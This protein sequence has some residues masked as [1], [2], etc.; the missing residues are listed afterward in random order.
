MKDFKPMVEEEII[1]EC[2]R[3]AR[4]SN[5][6]LKARMDLR[7]HLSDSGKFRLEEL[8]AALPYWQEE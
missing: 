3:L 8:T 5:V 2:V 7:R 4:A 6:L 1:G